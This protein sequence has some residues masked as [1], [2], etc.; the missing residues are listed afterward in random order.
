VDCGKIRRAVPSFQPQWNARRGARQLYDA[1]RTI[2]LTAADL[3]GTRYI[4]LRRI[5][6]LLA[7]G[8]LD[9]SLRWHAAQPAACAP[10][11]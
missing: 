6:E 4:R 3:E 11:A 2:R 9:S 5:K 1:Y 10:A 8:V 7:A